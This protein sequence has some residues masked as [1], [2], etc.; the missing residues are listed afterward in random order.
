[1]VIIRNGKPFG[2]ILIDSNESLSNV[3]KIV[4]LKNLL[5][6]DTSDIIAYYTNAIKL[7]KGGFGN[8]KLLISAHMKKLLQIENDDIR[9]INDHVESQMRGLLIS[10]TTH[11]LYQSWCLKNST[12]INLIISRQISIAISLNYR[13]RWRPSWECWTNWLGDILGNSVFKI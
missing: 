4:Y 1:M 9:A 11:S 7:L 3:Q 8:K 10:R 2:T 13:R 12:R 5:W 6:A